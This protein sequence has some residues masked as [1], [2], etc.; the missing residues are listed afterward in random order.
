M[1]SPAATPTRFCSAMP[2]SKKR[3][4]K[5]SAKSWLLV[6]LAR[7]ASRTTRFAC[8]AP[9]AARASPNAWRLAL[10]LSL[11]VVSSPD[12]LAKLV[13]RLR[14]L[15]ARG[16]H[17]VPLHEVRLHE[18]DALALD[19]VG[20]DH[21]RL[22]LALLR[23]RVRVEDRVVVVAVDAAGEPAERAHLALDRPDRHPVGHG[24]GAPLLVGG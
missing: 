13:A 1:A 9:S 5:R 14:T 12:A 10:G 24:P 17:A 6:L 7:S 20:H 23:P 22:A 15:L 19:R 4:G 3:S 18:G 16:R 2:I 11:I 8:S 21:L